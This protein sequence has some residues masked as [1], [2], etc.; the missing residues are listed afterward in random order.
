MSLLAV[1]ASETEE[2][3]TG[4]MDA[5]TYKE[6]RK[7]R[8]DKAQADGLIDDE[9]YEAMWQH[10][11]DNAA[12]GNFGRGPRGYETADSEECVLGEEGKMGIFRNENAGLRNGQGNGMGGR[13]GARN[14]TG[15]RVQDGSGYGAAGAGNHGGGRGM[16]LQDGSAGNEDC[17]LDN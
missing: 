1:S 14:G 3:T 4:N 13:N 8:L 6:L 16:M 15:E 11:Q 9:Q 12:E 5:E 2:T 7:A 10:I 17:I